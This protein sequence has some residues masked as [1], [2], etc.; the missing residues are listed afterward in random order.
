MSVKKPNHCFMK[1]NA[2]KINPKL[3]INFQIVSILVQRERKFTK[4]AH[5]NINGNAII[6]TSK[7]NHTTHKTEVG[8]IVHTFTQRI[9]ANA[10]D[11]DKIHVHTNANTKTDITFE[12]CKI[13]VI[14]IQLRND[15]GIDDVNFFI[16][17][18]NHQPEK[19]ATDCS[20]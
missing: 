2:R 8:I 12:L 5:K 7:L 10:E 15:F 16:K 20:I 4:T 13:I 9:T 11:K 19:F 6:L 18:L 17:F 3:S 1:E 14:N